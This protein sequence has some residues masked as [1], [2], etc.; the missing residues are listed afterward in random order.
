MRYWVLVSAVLLQLCL[1]ATYSWSVFAQALREDLGVPLGSAQVPYSVFYIVFPL[2]TMIAGKV[3]GRLGPTRTA[4]LGG[5]LFGAGWL[6]AGLGGQLPLVIAGVGLLSGL[7]VGIG[8]VVP[9]ATAVKWFPKQQGLVTGIAVAGFGGSAAIVTAV[10]S[11]IMGAGV[12]PFQTFTAFGVVFVVLTFL[13]AL[14]LRNP[15]GSGKLSPAGGAGPGAGAAEPGWGTFLYLYTGMFAGLGIGMM[16]NAN[17]RQMAGEEA[18]VVGAWAVSLFAVANAAGRILWGLF[19]DKVRG[20]RV[21]G[22]NLLMQVVVVLGFALLPPITPLYLTLA[23]LAGLNFG[24]VLVLYATT[25]T[26]LWG[27]NR[28][29]SIYGRVLSSYVPAAVGPWLMGVFYDAYGSFLMPLLGGALVLVVA[30]ALVIRVPRAEE[31]PS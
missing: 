12:S 18:V 22:A 28:F 6:L 9:I 20:P 14:G 7:G 25:V 13:A 11:R 2:T 3:L 31:L 30:A 5:A 1:G 29:A 21:P 4:M 24:G 26:R 16:I 10:A 8:Y 15:P 19:F 17:L 27:E 23:V